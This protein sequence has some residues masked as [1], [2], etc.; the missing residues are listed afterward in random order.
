MSSSPSSQVKRMFVLIALEAKSLFAIFFPD[1]AKIERKTEREGFILRD[2]WEL[3]IGPGISILSGIA[4][5]YRLKVKVFGLH[6]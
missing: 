1:G 5:S 6:Q 3:G 4:S 2:T